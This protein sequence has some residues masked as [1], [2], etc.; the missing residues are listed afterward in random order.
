MS[1]RAR[2]LILAVVIL[3]AAAVTAVALVNNKAPAKPVVVKEKAWLV[4]AEVVAPGAWAP[5]LTLYGRVESL[6]SSALTAGVTADVRRVAVIEGDSVVEGHL[7]VSLDDRDAKLLLQ[8]REAEYAEVEARIASELSRHTANEASLPRERK[9]LDL[10]LAEVNRLRNLVQKKVGAQ[11]QLDTARQAVEKQEIAVADR[12]QAVREHTSRM[13]ELQA[14]RMRA[15]ALRDQAQLELERCEITAPFNARV[16]KLQ[17]SPGSRV[18]IGDPLLEVFDTA[19][20]IVRAQLPTRYLA[21]V[22]TAQTE[23]M[24]LRVAGEIDGMR[25]VARLL[26]LAGQVAAA[27][28]GVEALFAIEQG[29]GGLQQGRFVRLDLALPMQN[30]VIAL[31]YEALYGDNRVY[32]IDAQRRMEAVPV[33]RIGESR[34]IAGERR[35]LIETADLREGDRV[36]TTQLP[37]AIAGLLVRTPQP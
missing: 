27:T 3:A 31:P 26:R 21:A 24:E 15:R 32:R 28:G 37:N 10:T 16:A 35:V 23:D 29:S 33:K 2:K 5:V 14:Q 7:L 17:V 25:V 6:W 19:A 18:R 36:I 1:I 20:L 4:G 34:T 22:R 11:S 12:A 30:D 13:A 8:Q 9:V